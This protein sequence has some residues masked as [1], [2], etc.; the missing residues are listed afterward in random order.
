MAERGDKE[1]I[2]VERMF[3]I[4]IATINFE[5]LLTNLLAGAA[6]HLSPLEERV[7]A[8]WL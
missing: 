2:K 4:K 1:G 6:S 5:D 3:T 8:H 7:N